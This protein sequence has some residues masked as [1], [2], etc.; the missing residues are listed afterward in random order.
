[1][2]KFNCLGI[3]PEV[4]DVPLKMRR[5]EISIEGNLFLS[6]N[7]KVA[8]LT[9]AFYKSQI[10][11]LLFVNLKSILGQDKFGFIIDIQ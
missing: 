8:I 11:Y 3:Y 9:R 1:M 6:R 7:E 10:T 5:N 4:R 2:V